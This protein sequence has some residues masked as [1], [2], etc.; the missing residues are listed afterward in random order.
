[1][2]MMI[3][4]LKDKDILRNILYAGVFT[5]YNEKQKRKRGIKL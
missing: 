2:L 1:M 4:S 3:W 5:K